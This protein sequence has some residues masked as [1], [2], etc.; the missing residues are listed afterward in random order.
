MV[1][2]EGTCQPL[3]VRQGETL[4]AS[5]LTLLSATSL[6]LPVHFFAPAGSL[7]IPTPPPPP[8]LLLLLL[9]PVVVRTVAPAPGLPDPIVTIL[10]HS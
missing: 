5:G 2:S 3:G 1:V 9:A 10:P 4:D 7:V 8:P 6:L